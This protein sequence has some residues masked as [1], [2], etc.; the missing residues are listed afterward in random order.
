MSDLEA[1]RQSA[2]TGPL[3]LVAAAVLW[4]T[5]GVLSK[6]IPWSALSVACL[7]G[8]IAAGVQMLYSRT[9]RV[10]IT[11]PVLLTAICYLGETCLFMFANKMT[12]AGSAIVLQ[13]TSPL[14]IILLSLLVLRQKPSRLDLCVGTVIF[15]GIVLSM[16]DTLR[17]GELPGTNPTLGNLLALL[18]GVFYAGIFFTSRLPGANPLH[19]TILGNSLYVFFLPFLLR[20]PAVMHPASAGVPA[21][22]SWLAIFFMGACQLGLSWICFSKGIRT[23][24]SLQASFITM[25]EPVLNPILALLF[26]GEAMGLLSVMGS[27]LVVVTII[28]HNVLTEQRRKK[29]LPAENAS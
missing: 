17:G 9:F 15:A 12:S 21:W 7:R 4:S 1:K 16:I 8:L 19:S 18:S 25:V 23:T 24:P 14:Y 26:L 27:A 22:Q 10:K 20:D 2:Y 13:N 29:E 3:F 6:F 28:V 11:W 5:A